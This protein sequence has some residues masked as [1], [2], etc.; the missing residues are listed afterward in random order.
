MLV[1]ATGGI[2]D[3]TLVSSSLACIN[4]TRVEVNDTNNPSSILQYGNNNGHKKF[5]ITG[6][7]SRKK[8]FFLLNPYAE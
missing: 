7:M 3:F 2:R 4:Q 1:F 6:P 8:T 5:Y